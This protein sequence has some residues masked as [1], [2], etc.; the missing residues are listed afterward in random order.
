MLI[1]TSSR[2]SQQ[3]LHSLSGFAGVW[4]KL[5]PPQGVKFCGVVN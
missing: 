5:S 1:L 2:N 4:G 3:V